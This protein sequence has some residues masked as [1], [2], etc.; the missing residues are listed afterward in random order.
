V[1]KPLSPEEKAMMDSLT[2]PVKA[3][4]GGVWGQVRLR[5]DHLERVIRIELRQY[6]TEE[7]K[8]FLQLLEVD[9]K[10]AFNLQ[11]AQRERQVAVYDANTGSFA[12]VERGNKVDNNTSVQHRE[13]REDDSGRKDNT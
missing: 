9:G 5:P 2:L 10:I 3:A 12:Y 8:P 1:I 11:A 7:W 4:G 6:A 13:D